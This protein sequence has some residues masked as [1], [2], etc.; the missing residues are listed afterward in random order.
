M[1]NAARKLIELFPS[2]PSDYWLERI[3][4][5]DVPC[6]RVNDFDTIWDDPQYLVNETFY[7]YE[8]P[9]AGKVRAVRPGTRLSGK[10]PELW[11]HAP[12]LGEHTDEILADFGFDRQEIADL[13]SRAIVK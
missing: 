8:H 13:H 5:A 4:K 2:Q 7:E 3:E 10:K 11:R 12:G 6:G 9:V 1:K